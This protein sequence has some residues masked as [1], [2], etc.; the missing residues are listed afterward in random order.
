MPHPI[1]SAAVTASTGLAPLVSPCQSRLVMLCGIRPYRRQ[2]IFVL[3]PHALPRIHCVAPRLWFP[4]LAGK[5][6][7]AQADF[8]AERSEAV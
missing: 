3:H 2:S 5:G 7:S 1:R 4:L 6:Q 8:V